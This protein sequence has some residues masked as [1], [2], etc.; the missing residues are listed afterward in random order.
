MPDYKLQFIIDAQNKA[1]KV[2]KQVETGMGKI[3]KRLKDMQPAFKKMAMIGTAAFAAVT[4]AVYKCVQAYFA[5][6]R[7]EARLAHLLKQTSGATKEQVDMLKLQA[8]A[9]QKVGV[10]G[11]EV[12]MM[13]QSQL[14]TFAL[15]A[16][17]IKVLT[18]SLMDM[19]VSVKGVN[20]TQED[21]ITIGNL[22]GKVMAGQVGALGRYGVTLSDTQIEQLKMGTEMERAT[23]LAEVLEG[24]YGGLN[25]ATRETAEGGM[26]ALK[27]EMGDLTEKIGE[28]FIPMLE[29]VIEKVSPVVEKMDKW[30]KENPELTKTIIIVAAAIAGLVAIIGGLGLI[31]PGIIAGFGLL[32]VPVFIIIGLLAL[33]GLAIYKIKENWAK[34]LETLKW[35]WENFKVGLEGIW[36]HIHD[37]F[38]ETWEGIKSDFKTGVNFLIGLAEGWANMWV[39]AVN[40]IIGALNKLKISVP[41]WVPGIGGKSWGVNIAKAAEVVLPRLAKG[42]LIMGPTAVLAG[43]KEPEAIVPLS[44]MALAGGT[45]NVY[46][47]GGNY[48]SRDAALMF[49]KEIAKEVKRNIKL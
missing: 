34:D 2:F 25:E 39:K 40:V 49:G 27:N 48:L 24:N 12:V 38:V 5:Q 32:S 18:P 16:D 13:G 44:R 7:T 45:I 1:D 28:A 23:V 9:L 36:T 41:W 47:Q 19:A 11:D 29:S 22:L 14:A 35:I 21:M 6:E 17:T 33:L 30:I 37:F 46:I 26:K 42:G 31:L 10:V 3:Q 8:T 43:E 15:N 4:A 20:V